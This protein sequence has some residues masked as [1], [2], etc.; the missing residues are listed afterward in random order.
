MHRID[1]LHLD[2]P[3]AGTRMLRDMVRREALQS[4]A[5]MCKP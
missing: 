5:V 2:Y 3:L 1:E 4:D